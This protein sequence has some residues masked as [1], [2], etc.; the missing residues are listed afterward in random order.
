[1]GNDMGQR[2]SRHSHGSQPVL[3][4]A[5]DLLAQRGYAGLTLQEIQKR[6][7]A[8]GVL[9]EEEDLEDIEDLA[10]LEDIVVIALAQ[11]RLFPVPEP[12]GS[13]RADLHAL[14]RP[15]LGPRGPEERA[16]AAVLSAAESN[17]RLRTAVVEAFDRPLAQAVGT[18]LARATAEGHV[19][20]GRV[21]TLTWILRGLALNRLRAIHP[22]SHVDL[23]EL[24]DHLV[25]GLERAPRET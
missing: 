17:A 21:Q 5:L 12:M 1:M 9:S 20:P 23:E 14:L 18:L 10:D 13:L 11:V 7:R 16:V 24:V 8:A 4:A 15:W 25:V 19:P 22:R 3:T 2:L 6:S